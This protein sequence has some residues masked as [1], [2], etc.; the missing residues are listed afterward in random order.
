MAR[1]RIR[2]IFLA[3]LSA[4]LFLGA[5]TAAPPSSGEAAFR[6]ARTVADRGNWKL[7]EEKVDAALRRFNSSDDDWYWALQALRA[8]VL[9]GF[10]RYADARSFLSRPLPPRLRNSETAVR[11]LVELATAV[12]LLDDPAGGK[13]LFREARALAMAKQPH[14]LPEVL[15][16]IASFEAPTNAEK[17]A[18]QALRLA[19]QVKDEVAELG[20]LNQIGYSCAKQGRWVE[21]V[22]WLEQVPSRARAAQLDKLVEKAEGNLGWALGE[23]G[24]TERAA[25]LFA[26]ADAVAERIGAIPDRTAWLTQLGN[27]HFERD[28]FEAARRDYLTSYALA[29]ETGNGSLGQIVSN[30]ATVSLELGK[31]EDARKYNA[32]ALALKTKQEDN[33][34]AILISRIVEARLAEAAKRYDQSEEI[35]SAVITQSD[36]ASTRWEA[37][38][39][40]AALY[41][42]TNRPDLAERQFRHA[43][44]RFSAARSSITDDELRLTFNRLL[45][46]LVDRYVSFLV[47]RE[48]PAAALDVAEEIRGQSLEEGLRLTTAAKAIDPRALAKKLRATLLCYRLGHDESHLW[49]IT[50]K[51]ITATVLPSRRVIETAVDTYQRNLLG[52][53]G[54]LE[55][56][57]ARGSELYRMLVEPAAASVAPGSFVILIPDGRLW[58]LNFETLVVPSSKPHYWIEDVVVANAVSLQLIGRATAKLDASPS[59]LLIGNPPMADPAFPALTRA[60][61][62]IA[63]ISKRFEPNRSMVL[64]RAN[65]TPAAYKTVAPESY[66]YIHFV[67][68]GEATRSKP[69]DSAV[70]LSRDATGDYR[71]LARDIV[72]RTLNARLVTISSCHGAGIQTYVGEGLVGLAWAFLRAGA[73]NVVASLWDVSDA[74]TPELMDRMYAG[75]RAGRPPAAALRDAKKTLLAS[76]AFRNPRFWAPFIFYIGS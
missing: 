24:N 23:L 71:L 63:F 47:Q 76:K 64:S 10:G 50:P 17:T 8:K 58:M 32:E 3:L 62:E 28:D 7:A 51:T 11:R 16:Y 39:W 44:D 53:L 20:A 61:E 67:A 26:D 72:K 14:L 73:D 43:L 19:R 30:L 69:L 66:D 40:L 9:N 55:R 27:V 48:R 2:K 59:L 21:A 25:E 1:R 68:H 42:E 4:A 36:V 45:D 52:P 12:W 49:T 29:K 38:G 13:K 34:D 35:L 75:I 46:R 65:A 54:S 41:A 37:E 56:S 22:H 60:G 31:Y 5:T 70:I 74:A 33:P 18:R 57:G 6:E 15:V